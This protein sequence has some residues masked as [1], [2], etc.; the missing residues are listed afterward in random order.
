LFEL[1]TRFRRL[2]FIRDRTFAPAGC[3][4]IG[5]QEG[6][7]EG[8]NWK[9]HSRF[10]VTVSVLALVAVCLALPAFG[11]AAKTYVGTTTCKMCHNKPAEGAQF[12][13]WMNTKHAKAMETLKSD[14]AK[15]VSDKLGLKVAPAE[16]PDCLRC[17]VTGYDKATKKAPEK[18]KMEEGVGCESCHG[19]ASDHFALA[20][21]NM[22]DKSVDPKTGIIVKPD[23]KSCTQCHNPESPTWNPEQYTTAD[24]KKVGFDFKQAYEK[25]KHPNPK[26]AAAAP[27]K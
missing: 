1:R 27:A 17:H 21:K 23:E 15:A 2:D 11:Q 22:T 3:A 4:A 7:E 10:T 5:S 24:G 6:V 20:K 8:G 26:H 19:P 16:N 13:Q 9:M 18:I 25:I 12:T 14:A